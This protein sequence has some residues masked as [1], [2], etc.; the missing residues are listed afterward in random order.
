[1][2]ELPLVFFTIFG[3][4]S[5]G[6]V[7][8]GSLNS[9]FNRSNHNTLIIEKVN[10]VALVFMA[11]GMLLASFHLGK[12]F[13]ALNVIF[14]IG[15][16][17]M[18]NE[19]FTFGVLFGVTFGCV[20]LAYF[21]HLNNSNRWGFIKTLCQRIN[22]IPHISKI[23]AVLLVIISLV[24]VWTIVLTYMLPT[25]KTWGTYYTAIQMYTAML[26]LGG[27]MVAMLGF[28]RTGSIAFFIGAL[29]ILLLKLPYINLMIEIA[30]QLAYDQYHWVAV[31]CGL[32]LV[33]LILIAINSWRSKKITMV[34]MLGFV[35]TLVAELCGRIAFYNL[36]TIPL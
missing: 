15:R 19:I 32:L 23:L 13:R 4:L 28:H 16:S 33:A 11:L 7:L 18:S 9:L 3:Q 22:Q 21:S 6:M 1:M 26:V 36:W 17:P 2:H 25:V 8:L 10:L 31:Q 35:C 5:A 34:Y 30:P 29:L 27:V 12:P 20:I 24:F 14:G